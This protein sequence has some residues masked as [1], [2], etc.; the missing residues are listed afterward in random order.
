VAHANFRGEFE[1]HCRTLAGQKASNSYS[2]RRKCIEKDNHAKMSWVKRRLT[3]KYFYYPS[4]GIQRNGA[5]N[6]F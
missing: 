3:L 5:G 2:T 6:S 4:L 1:R